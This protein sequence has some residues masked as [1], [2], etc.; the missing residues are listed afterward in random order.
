MAMVREA[1]HCTDWARLRELLGLLEALQGGRELARAR[2]ISAL[3]RARHPGAAA[4]ARRR[5][6]RRARLRA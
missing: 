5:G 2:G 4:L 3:V 6:A 1:G